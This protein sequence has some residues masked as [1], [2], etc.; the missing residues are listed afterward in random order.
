M[1]RRLR[2]LRGI[3]RPPR[4]PRA[5]RPPWPG[6]AR[7][8]VVAPAFLAAYLSLPRGLLALLSP[9]PELAL[10][11]GYLNQ[12]LAY[13]YALA[14][15]H[16]LAA[17]WAPRGAAAALAAW[18][19]GDVLVRAVQ[20]V[21]LY[22]FG[23]GYSPV[24]FAHLEPETFALAVR[25]FWSLMLSAAAGIAAAQWALGRLLRPGARS[26]EA[27]LAAAGLVLMGLYGGWALYRER[28]RLP[29][30]DLAWAALAVNAHRYYGAQ[31]PRVR[32]AP[33]ERAVAR[34]LGF[35]PPARA[36]REE[37]RAASGRPL[38]LVVVYLEGFQAALADPQGPFPGLTPALNRWRGRLT[39]FLAFY[40][41]ATPTINALLS[42]QCG[43]LVHVDNVRLRV[44]RGFARGLSCLTDRLAV[45]GYTQVFL[46]GASSGFAGKRLF[47]R[48]HGVDEVWG[49]EDWRRRP[50]YRRRHHEWGLHDTD[51]VREALDAVER[52]RRDPPFHL[53]LLTLNTHPP[54]YRAPDCPVY[55]ERASLLNGYR[56]TDEAV[57]RLLDGL[58]A[59]GVLRDTAVALVGDHPPFPGPANRK[60]LGGRVPL[61]W[62]GRV[63]LAVHDPRGRLPDVV[64]A[65]GYTPD[66]APTLLALTGAS[67]P[68][69]FP[70][71]QS[72]LEAAPGRRLV[73]PTFEVAGGR[74]VPAHPP[75]ENPCPARRAAAAV[76]GPA[77]G[78]L[79]PCGRRR[80]FLW[81]RQ[82]LL[83]VGPGSAGAAR[84]GALHRGGSLL[85]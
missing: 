65:P 18:V 15:A 19:H 7:R 72:L 49:W 36:G 42:S 39:R 4:G 76:I 24:V 84:R 73:A 48:R 82:G 33:R 70:L 22:R 3:P 78:P 14:G 55:R 66:L 46:G 26:R 44:D 53:I 63:V 32:L 57:G 27:A 64:A 13:A 75:L 56:C 54:G 5:H 45:A 31:P 58:E 79:G 12:T 41:A 50:A 68:R 21:L 71:G 28:H 10:S 62:Y 80:L 51:L 69:S 74:M 35:A 25:Q 83:T 52:L 43:I 30:G 9:Q 16:A 11:P 20:A 23:M 60:L 6:L 17:W 1:G 40:A 8:W 77:E 2:T 38:N 34:R 61:R 81:H 85:E 59:R 37:A 47:W 29:R 67:A